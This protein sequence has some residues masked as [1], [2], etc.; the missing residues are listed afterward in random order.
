MSRD[1]KRGGQGGAEK[2]ASSCNEKI[3]DQLLRAKPVD[4]DGSVEE[5]PL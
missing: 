3:F 4:R 2:T 5:L 1:G